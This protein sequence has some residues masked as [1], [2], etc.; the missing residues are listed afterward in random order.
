MTRAKSAGYRN[1]PK[2]CR[3]K[4]GKSGNPKGRPR[5]SLNLTTALAGELGERISVRENGKSLRVSKQG[6]LLKT[7]VAKALQG[8][9]KAIGTVLTLSARLLDDKTDPDDGAIALDELLV[10]R[11]YAPQFLKQ[12]KARKVR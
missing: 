11:K 12:P 5:G 10:L 9:I 8:D 2:E 6:A 7:L 3:F 1:P 4:P